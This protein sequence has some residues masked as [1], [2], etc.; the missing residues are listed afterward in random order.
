MNNKIAVFAT[1][2]LGGMVGLQKFENEKLKTEKQ[3]IEVEALS[4]VTENNQMKAQVD[5]HVPQEFIVWEKDKNG[6]PKVVKTFKASRNDVKSRIHTFSGNVE[7]NFKMH[8][9]LFGCE[10][11]P[12]PTP[13]PVPDPNEPKPTQVQDWGFV[14]IKAEEANKIAPTLGK[15]VKVCVIDT[16]VGP[17]DDLVVTKSATFVGGSTSDIYG[18]GTH[19]AG[20]IAA[21]DNTHGV[22]GGAH[23]IVD[24]INAKALGDDGSGALTG[25]TQAINFCGQNGAQIVNGSLGGGPYSQM[26][27]DTISFW[28][29]KG[30]KFVFSAGNDGGPTNYPAAYNIPGLFSVSATDQNDMIA[31]FSSRGKV[32]LAGPGVNI[33]S[34][35]PEQSKMAGLTNGYAKASGTSMAAP[36]VTA[37][38]AMA[39][40][41]GLPVGVDSVGDKSLYGQGR[42]D[43]LKS[44]KQ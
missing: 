17:H 26:M 27:F 19:V 32:E 15:R 28:T 41:S 1:V 4:L 5:E 22:V 2:V 36:E 24:I 25:I 12:S 23:S 8:A 9:H 42:V 13:T 7:E 3:E 34:T 44:V 6:L 20:I 11:A 10:K 31:S 18:H 29:N 21:I 43:A 30:V 39:I 38:L 14:K 33:L 40:A 16:G 37:A 35:V